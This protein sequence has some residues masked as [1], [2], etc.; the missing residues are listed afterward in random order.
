MLDRLGKRGILC[1]DLTVNRV[2]DKTLAVENSN[3]FHGNDITA[4]LQGRIRGM[5]AF[6]SIYEY[7]FRKVKVGEK[8]AIFSKKIP[9]YLTIRR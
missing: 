1:C 6:H 8:S 9:P 2:V 7:R 3:Q 5:C 4:D